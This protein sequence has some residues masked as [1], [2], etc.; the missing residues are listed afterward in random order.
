MRDATVEWRTSLADATVDETTFSWG[1]KRKEKEGR[2]GG[3][4]ARVWGRE[5]GREGGRPLPAANS[6]C[7]PRDRHSSFLGLQRGTTTTGRGDRASKPGRERTL[8]E[9]R[10]LESLPRPDGDAPGPD[11]NA[12]RPSR[13]PRHTPPAQPHISDPLLNST[14]PISIRVLNL[15]LRS[16]S[17]T[18][19]VCARRI[20]AS[21]LM[22]SPCT[23]SRPDRG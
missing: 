20:H 14:A 4:G 12:R 22:L 19:R 18:S 3:Q 5:G 10:T 8:E 21:M 23:M 16:P 1:G 9:L 11:R 17:R 7:G 13:E 15:K 6:G 2:K